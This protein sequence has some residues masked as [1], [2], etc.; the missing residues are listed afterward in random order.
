MLGVGECME[1]LRQLLPCLVGFLN[2]P[3]CLPGYGCD[4]RIGLSNPVRQFRVHQLQ[5][6]LGPHRLACLHDGVDETLDFAGLVSDRTVTEGKM[7]VL[8]VTV[9]LD[10]QWKVLDE[11]G[12]P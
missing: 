10:P 2:C 1:P 11:S 8:G 4:H 7:T 3:Q 6:I 9:A 12:G 5:L